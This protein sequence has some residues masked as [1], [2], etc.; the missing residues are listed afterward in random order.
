M[1]NFNK[2]AKTWETLIKK[3]QIA[4]DKKQIDESNKIFEKL[5]D[6]ALAS[7][8]DHTLTILQIEGACLQLDVEING[9]EQQKEEFQQLK[10]ASSYM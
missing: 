10:T 7:N 5:C 8:E 1:K 3:I 9:T 2:E 4:I 6:L